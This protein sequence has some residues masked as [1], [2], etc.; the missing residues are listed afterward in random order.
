M[1]AWP[2]TLPQSF[3]GTGSYQETPEPTTLRTAMDTGVVKLRRRTT[4]SEIRVSGT[5]YITGDQAEIFIGWFQD[6][7]KG[8]SLAFTAQ[9]TLSAATRVFQ[10][11]EEPNINHVGGDVFQ[12]SMKLLVLPV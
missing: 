5:M 3:D 7:I 2:D 12:L 6:T 11:V 8:G 9:L 4:R 10:F 1:V